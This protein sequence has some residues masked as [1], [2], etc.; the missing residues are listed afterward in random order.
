MVYRFV[1]AGVCSREIVIEV[2][3]DRI[4][5]DVTFV[6]GCSGNT[7]GVAALAKGRSIGEL[8]GKLQG[9]RCGSKIS[10]CPDQFAQALMK[11][12]SDLDNGKIAIDEENA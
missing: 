9:I 3:D 10:S 1:P 6:G 4:I 2:D 12:S 7:Q 8:I 11:I 5:R